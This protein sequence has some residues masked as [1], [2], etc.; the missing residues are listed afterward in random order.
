M[1]YD[2]NLAAN[3]SQRL[4]VNGQF[5]KYISG[6]G[7]I[8]VTT[9]KG[10]VIDLVQGQGVWGESFSALTVQD[11]SGSAN[12]GVLLAG[13]YDFR[14]DNVNIGGAVQI[15]NDGSHRVPVDS[16]NSPNACYATNTAIAAGTDATVTIVDPSMNVRGIIVSRMF[17]QQQNSS[18]GRQSFVANPNGPPAGDAP[19]GSLLLH[20]VL[21]SANA[22]MIQSDAA[23]F[24]PPGMGLYYVCRNSSGAMT[25]R[26]ICYR[27]L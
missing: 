10:A 24:I 5:F 23:V 1:Q 9:N 27:V 25:C 4:E 14:D 22:E 12:P 17:I 21:P 15:G 13:S 16:A 7:K 3:D 26:S 19:A 8:R 2:L 20:W 11:R 18:N 6:G